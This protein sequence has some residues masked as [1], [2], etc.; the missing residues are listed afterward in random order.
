MWSWLIPSTQKVQSRSSRSSRAPAAQPRAAVPTSAP[1]LTCETSGVDNLKARQEMH[2]IE[3]RSTQGNVLLC[4]VCTIL[5]VSVIGGNVLMNCVTRF[6]ASSSQVRAWKESLYAAEAGG[7]IAYAEVRKTILNPTN[8]FAGWTNSGGVRT[9]SPVT[10]GN[11][12]LTTSSKVDSF[13]ND[14]NG[15]SWYRIRAQGT[16]PVLGLKRV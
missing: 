5:I 15:S 8:A 12:S 1:W 2:V 9:N 4:V 7:D 11:D 16:V 10:F 6:N 3:K 13:W 14:S